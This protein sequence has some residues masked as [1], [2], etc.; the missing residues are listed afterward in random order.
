[1]SLRNLFWAFRPYVYHLKPTD[2][3]YLRISGVFFFNNQMASGARFKGRYEWEDPKSSHDVVHVIFKAKDGTEIR[4]A[5][6]VNDNLMYLARRH[7]IEIEGACE[8]S[9]ACSTCHVYVNEEMFDKLPEP[10][11][12]ENDMLDLAPFLKPN[13]RLSCQIILTKELDGIVIELPPATRNFYPMLQRDSGKLGVSRIWEDILSTEIEYIKSN[14]D[15]FGLF[16]SVDT[17]VEYYLRLKKYADGKHAS[18]ALKNLHN[19]ISD[20]EGGLIECKDSEKARKRREKG[21]R[22]FKSEDYE[23]ASVYY[24]KGILIAEKDSKELAL[25]HGNLSA[26]L[27]HQSKWAACIWHVCLALRIQND[28]QSPFGKRLQLRLQQACAKIGRK[29]LPNV[30]EYY[31]WIAKLCEDPDPPHESEERYGFVNLPIPMFGRSE[32]LKALSSRLVVHES[33]KQGRYVVSEGHFKAGDVLASEP[34]GGWAKSEISCETPSIDEMAVACCILLP[35]QRHIRCLACH[36][37]LESVGYVCPH[38]NDAA[39]CGPPSRCFS[40]HFKNDRFIIPQWHKDEC[41]YIFLLNSIGLGHLCFRLGTL[42]GRY[43]LRTDREASLDSLVDNYG[44]FPSHFEY[45]LTGWLCG[46]LMGRIGLPNCGDWCF[47]LLH[48]LQC[49][50]HAITQVTTTVSR[51]HGLVDMVQERVGGGLF[52]IASLI[53]HACEPNIAYQFM[54]GFIV[55][56]CIKDISPGD[57]ILAC[58]GPHFRHNPDTSARKRALLEQYFFECSC[59]HCDGTQNVAVLSPRESDERCELVKQIRSPKTPLPALPS[60]FRRLKDLSDPTTTM[61]PEPSYGEIADEMAFG[62]L[63]EAMTSSPLEVRKMALYLTTE[64]CD[65]VRARFG[66]DS[67]EYAW[68]LLKLVSVARAAGECPNDGI[69]AT[70]QRIMEIYHGERETNRILNILCDFFEWT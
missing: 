56:R 22:Y 20:L 70:F 14:G 36:N 3:Q 5:G 51:N 25:L 67:I 23:T 47:R 48:R 58:Y 41:R 11:D 1:M 17:P 46:L 66:A 40:R 44:H 30:S 32:K 4:V 69:K 45:G 54:N 61:T 63:K 28:L 19:F 8:A 7:G 43:L 24:R 2:S 15:P 34:A 49:N 6:K 35:F 29:A 52:P 16:K 57:E 9:L 68:E 21:N 53:N 39:F 62:L 31:E 27:L 18:Q 37:Q 33:P 10:K 13:S 12:E 65:F 26:C 42:R 38:C 55:I 59:V 64:S 50:A 60:L